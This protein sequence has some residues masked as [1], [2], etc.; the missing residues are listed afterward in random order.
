MRR[1]ARRNT[2]EP[3]IVDGLREDDMVVTKLSQ[4]GLPDLL[5]L[6]CGKFM[7]LEVLGEDG[8]LTRRQRA[9][10]KANAAGPCAA[11]KNLVEARAAVR[12]LV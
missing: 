9:F 11:V 6:Y 7:L 8:K 1:A 2:E 12:S 4:E 10:F 3:S 5:V